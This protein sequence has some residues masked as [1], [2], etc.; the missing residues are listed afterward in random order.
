MELISKL[1]TSTLIFILSLLFLPQPAQ[2]AV[3]YSSYTGTFLAFDSQ[4]EQPYL[5]LDFVNGSHNRFSWRQLEPAEGKYN[6]SSI[7]QLLTKLASV[8]KKLVLGLVLRCQS[9]GSIFD[10]CA[11]DWT[12]TDKYGVIKTNY[13]GKE[14]RLLNYANPNLQFRLS[15]LIQALADRYSHNPNI[16]AVEIGPGYFG[17]AKPMPTTTAVASRLV[18]KQAYLSAWGGKAPWQAYERFLLSTYNQAFY[19]RNQSNLPMTVVYLGSFLNPWEQVDLVKATLAN[20]IG[21]HHSGLESNFSTSANNGSERICASK[22][23]LNDPAAYRGHWEA[24]ERLGQDHVVSFEFHHWNPRHG[25]N[26]TETE[27][28]WWS[29]FNALDKKGR[30]IYAYKQNLNNQNNHDA[31]RFFN[32]Y[33]GKTAAETPDAW[34]ALRTFIDLNKFC[35]DE[36]NYDFY[37]S[38]NFNAAGGSLIAHEPRQPGYANQLVRSK[39]NNDWYGPYSRQPDVRNHKPY[40]FFKLD[41]AFVAS[42]PTTEYQVE[43]I[44]W[45]GNRQ[46]AGSSWQFLY[47]ATT[48][49][50]Q[51]GKTITLTG[52]QRW[53]TAKF[54]I[55]DVT[56]SHRLIDQAGRPG[57]DIALYTPDAVDDYFA[58]IKLTPVQSSGQVRFSQ[59]N[60]IDFI[61]RYLQVKDR[62]ISELTEADES[63]D[64]NRD[65]LFDFQD[66]IYVIVDYLKNLN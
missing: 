66:I 37:L 17:E 38:Q 32:K 5:N 40:L 46:D 56:F 21:L 49:S 65:G 12:L 18:Q 8:N 10:L 13:Q 31:F 1:T 42:R 47:S 35:P 64:I 57:N 29:V 62:P 11:P 22:L 9:Q 63:Y 25:Y 24:T 61:V 27:H 26:L 20:N 4:G 58:F 6:F 52:S 39:D 48:N 50:R 60:V 14:L 33:A 3:D 36:G 41:D 45:D 7:D 43:I 59:A 53:L 44:Y 54:D 15:K 23:P 19:Q 2:A 30:V 51:L 34:I 28:V 55:A 16:A